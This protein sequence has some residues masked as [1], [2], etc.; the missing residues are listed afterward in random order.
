M[1]IIASAAVSPKPFDV[2]H[3]LRSLAGNR[4]AARK[5]TTMFLDM[6][7]GKIALL[8]AALQAADWV[9]LRRVVH[10]LRGSC[11]MF[12]ATDCLSLASKLEGVL[13]DH[14]GPQLP[15]DCAHFKEALADLAAELRQFLDRQP[16][17]SK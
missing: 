3:L 15:E 10:D 2:D 5:L 8:D 1:S 9:A 14:V 16:E 6:Y 13:P 17:S 7:P 12:S 11:G 4:P